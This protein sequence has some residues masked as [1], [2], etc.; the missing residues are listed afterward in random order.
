LKVEGK[1]LYQ[2][3]LPPELMFLTLCYLVY[4]Y[5]NHSIIIITKVLLIVD[6]LSN[7][8]AGRDE[9]QGCIVDVK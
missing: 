2:I 3:Y 4:Y 9:K 7:N 6:N 1:K 5:Y 8:I